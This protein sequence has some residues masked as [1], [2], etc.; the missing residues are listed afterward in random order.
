MNTSLTTEE[1]TLLVDI[2][3]RSVERLVRDR[4][5]WRPQVEE[6]PDALR[7]P[8]G[9]FV[10][11][12][13]DGRLRGCVGRLA[14]TGPLGVTAAEVARSAATDDPRFAPVA[15][16]ELDQLTYAVSVLTPAEPLD[17]E[18]YEELG[19]TVRPGIDG[20]LVESGRHRATLLPSVWDD[21]PRVPAFLE[22]LWRKAGLR[23]GA[24]PPGTTVARYTAIEVGEGHGER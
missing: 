14:S 11:L 4:E 18:S 2:A 1:R 16:H 7:R 24:W 22:A 6:L 5:R 21:L 12:H 13:A 20:L 19:R 17:V 10:T 9:V 3:R 23:P 15:P 8:G